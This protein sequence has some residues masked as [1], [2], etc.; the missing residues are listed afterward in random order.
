MKTLMIAVVA[1]LPLMAAPVLAQSTG[2][3]G[4]HGTHGNHSN[5]QHGVHADATLNKMMDR[6]ANISHGPIKEIGWPAMTMDLPILEG[7]EIGDVSE[8]QPVM[9]M[10]EKGKDGMYGIKAMMPK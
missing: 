4:N 5:M 7:A 2:G 10:L 1:A 9:L 8:G 6:K 3:H